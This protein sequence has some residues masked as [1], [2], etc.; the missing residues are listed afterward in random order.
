MSRSCVDYV[1]S[2]EFVRVLVRSVEFWAAGMPNHEVAGPCVLGSA[3]NGRRPS[4]NKTT[5]PR[6]RFRGRR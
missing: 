3:G 2:P 1:P 4:I 6:Q 5:L